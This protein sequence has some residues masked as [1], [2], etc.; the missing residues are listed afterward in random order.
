M[1]WNTWLLFKKKNN[2]S[3]LNSITSKSHVC[4]SVLYLST[5]LLFNFDRF[6]VQQ[7]SHMHN[8]VHASLKG[9]FHTSCKVLITSPRCVIL[10]SFFDFDGQFSIQLLTVDLTELGE[11]QLILDVGFNWQVDENIQKWSLF[12]FFFFFIFSGSRVSH[13]TRRIRT[14]SA[15]TSICG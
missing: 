2:T 14:C 5:F 11:R 12:F 3:N 7:M 13:W 6:G 10:R 8:R 4:F 15:E 9:G 1:L